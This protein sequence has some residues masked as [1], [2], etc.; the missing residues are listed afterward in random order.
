[1]RAIG[2]VPGQPESAGVLEVEDPPLSDGQVLVRGILV[3]ICGTDAEIVH[4]GYGHVPEGASHLVIGHESLGQ[5]VEAPEGSGLR[6]GD[7]VVGMVRRPDP[8]PCPSCAAGDWDMCSNGGYVERGIKDA[9][10]YGSQWW[11]IDPAYAV[12]VDPALGRLGVLLET[13]SVVAKAWEQVD[14]I[15][16]RSRV[17]P[18]VALVTGAGPVGLLAALLARQRGLDTWVLDVVT[19]GPKPE[20]VAELGATYSS[21]PASELPVQ[22]DVVVECTGLGSVLSAVFAQAAPN[23]V[24][25]LAGVSH[26][27][28]LVEGDLDAVNRRLVLGNQVVFGTVNAGRRHFEQA[29][30]AL[31]VADPAWL[32]RLLTRQVDMAR[33]PESL[34][35]TA[36]D[37]KVTVSLD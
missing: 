24:L 15:G 7:M 17:A 14:R 13:T 5:V 36:D 6:P 4:Q 26:H 33:W 18:Q 16:T 23:A 11:R 19:D 20:L 30:H 10:G 25:A 37:I 35:K 31:G 3:G 1:M 27:S 2:V 12:K 34:V 32:G 8:V 22:P 28:K 29:G 21:A 9:P